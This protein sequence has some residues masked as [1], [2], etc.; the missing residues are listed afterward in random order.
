[1]EI[2]KTYKYFINESTDN[3]LELKRIE[4]VPHEVLAG[5]RKIIQGIYDRT[6]KPRFEVSNKGLVFT[7]V[8]TPTDF[9]FI[10][11]D[12]VLTLD[13]SQKRGNPYDIKLKVIDTISET[14]EV[15]YLVEYNLKGFNDIP[16][17]MDDEDL[18]DDLIDNIDDGTEEDEEFD[19]DVL[20]NEIKKNKIKSTKNASFDPDFDVY[21]DDDDF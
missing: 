18:D 7:F 11:Y 9:R 20:D 2:L 5:V 14:F 15:S 13:G 12:E 17:V 19:E 6:T 1:M 8:A 10:E 4:D 16:P 21:D 3:N